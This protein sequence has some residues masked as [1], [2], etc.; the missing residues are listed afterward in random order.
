MKLG[1]MVVNK[2]KKDVTKCD[3]GLNRKLHD[4]EIKILT[5]QLTDEFSIT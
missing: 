5:Y 2:F 4:K 1:N 3:F